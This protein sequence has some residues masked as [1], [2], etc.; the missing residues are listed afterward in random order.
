MGADAGAALP[1]Y[2]VAWGWCGLVGR[3]GR[4][5]G[6][7]SLGL[8]GCLCPRGTCWVHVGADHAR[9]CDDKDELA[10][11]R[12]TRVH[13]LSWVSPFVV[14]F[15]ARDVSHAQKRKVKPTCVGERSD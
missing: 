3:V 9:I 4:A 13:P 7:P 10:Q 6:G 8:R 12:M 11:Y 15:K 2:L 14:T 1:T 5:G